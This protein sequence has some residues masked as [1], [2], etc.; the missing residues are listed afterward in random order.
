MQN[1]TKGLSLDGESFRLAFDL[2][3]QPAWIHHAESGALLAVNDSAMVTFGYPWDALANMSGDDLLCPRSRRSALFQ[4]GLPLSF[5][6]AGKLKLKDGT[7]RDFDVSVRRV[8]FEERDAFL[9]LALDV[10]TRRAADAMLTRSER[11]LA[12]AQHIAHLA[13]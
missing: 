10:T 7:E 8:N 9:V 13:S 4:S 5:E 11:Q 3:A 12:E 6:D 2:L 1:A